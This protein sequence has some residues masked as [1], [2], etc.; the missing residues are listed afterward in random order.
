MPGIPGAVKIEFIRR[1]GADWRDLADIFDTRVDQQEHFGRAADPGRAVWDWLSNR[2][3]LAD[4]PAALTAIGRA[5]L[6]A[7][8][9][10][11]QP[12]PAADAV[13]FS[14][15]I[16]ERTEDF[17]GRRR[18]ARDLWD[19]FDDPAFGSGYL[20]VK[21]EPGIGKTALLA[22]LVQRYG[23]V[24]H[25]NSVLT[26]VTSAE[27]FLRNVCAQLVVAYRLPYR[28]LPDEVTADS[29]TLLKLLGEASRSERV[30][31]AVDA[32]D[33]AADRRT[34]NNRLLLPPALPRNT[35]VL[36]TLRDTE[37]IPLYVDERREMTIDERDPENVSD[38]REFIAAFLARHQAIMTARL[39]GL[40][41][42][43]SGFA[44]VLTDRSEG[45][46]MYLRHVL[47][48]VRDRTIGGDRLDS[49]PQGLQAYYAHL[50][51]Q[52]G[53]VHGAA[54]ERQL[55]ILAVLATWPE[56]LPVARLAEFAG[57]PSDTT[58]AVLRRW[59]GFLNRLDGAVPRYAL[60]H[61]SFRDFLA[62]RLDLADVRSQI[63]LSIED[64]LP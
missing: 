55:K 4:L 27:R 48:G 39:S 14:A 61:A 56:P 35:Y 12:D 42:D 63:A 49:L 17:V 33:E 44:A 28:R 25:F 50:E 18:L 47:R 43:E 3:R 10:G 59:A 51:S 13:D 57:E 29:A 8:I 30:I 62:G 52:L 24:H 26:G 15:L 19:T 37:G 11:H 32:L 23:L 34:G 22:S 36:L 41:L 40:G 20:I 9:E 2:D 64:S 7:L 16:D 1:L 21:G 5:D 45:N 6:A 38:A 31:I 58:A 46:F 60:Y 54:P 53:V